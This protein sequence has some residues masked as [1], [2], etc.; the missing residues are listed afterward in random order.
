MLTGQFCSQT[1]QC[2]ANPTVTWA[3]DVGYPSGSIDRRPPGACVPKPGPWN[4]L[5]HTAPRWACLSSHLSRPSSSSSICLSQA[6]FHLHLLLQLIYDFLSVALPW[7]PR[8]KVS[9]FEST[10]Y[11]LFE[12]SQ[13]PVSLPA[14]ELPGGTNP[15]FFIFISQYLF[16]AWH[17][18]GY[19]QIFIKNK[20]LRAV[21]INMLWYSFRESLHLL[22]S[23]VP[24]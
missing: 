2:F 22:T 8:I 23:T 4:L 19:Q 7:H 10:W 20:M 9:P 15:V 14:W 3:Q 24:F 6:S 13:L 1:F 17:L 18:S 21:N 12:H 11:A 5:C 16:Y